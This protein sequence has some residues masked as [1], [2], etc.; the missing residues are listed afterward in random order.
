MAFPKLNFKKSWKSPVDFPT[1][2]ASETQVRADLQELHDETA[3]YINTEMADYIEKSYM[4]K[5]GG[6]VE[7]NLRMGSHSIAFD[8]A[9]IGNFDFDRG[10]LGLRGPHEEDTTLRGVA[11]P[12]EDNDAANKQYV[13]AAKASTEQW[14]EDKG[15]LTAH[16]DIS[17][18]LNK[19][20]DVMIGTLSMG[21]TAELRNRIAMLADP[22]ADYDAVN[23]KYVDDGFIPSSGGRAIGEL[24]AAGFLL[25]DRNGSSLVALEPDGAKLKVIVAAG[26]GPLACIECAAPTADNDAANKAY[27]ESYVESYANGLNPIIHGTWDP[28][29]RRVTLEIPPSAPGAYVYLSALR[30]KGKRPE[31][32][33]EGDGWTAIFRLSKVSS[34][35]GYLQFSNTERWDDGTLSISTITV[36]ATG[37]FYTA[38]EF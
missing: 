25:Y 33:I 23:K 26:V 11:N 4:P 13:D 2:E 16:Q 32:Q 18:K 14:V 22:T 27:V 30:G 7:G 20:G 24:G 5:T 8:G 37:I 34:T 36:N 35:G 28:S 15:Y 38:T 21:A 1:Y 10:V 29:S 6:A 31:L 19:N 3:E 12:I 17:G 9:S